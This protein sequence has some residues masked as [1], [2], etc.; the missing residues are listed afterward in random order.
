MIYPTVPSV[1]NGQR[2]G[3]GAGEM[4]QHSHPRALTVPEIHGIVADYA[5]AARN[6]LDAGFDGVEIH[7]ANGYLINQF[8]DSEANNRTD[9]YGGCL[10]NRLRFLR[11]VAGAVADAVGPEKVGVRLAPLTTLQGA[12]DS[13][14]E[15]TYLAAVAAL[16]DIGIAYVHIAE[17]D[18]D[19]APDMPRTFKEALRSTFRGV[20]IYAGNYDKERAERALEEGW[21]DMIGFGRA[22]IA[23][24]DLPYRFEQDL[25]L[26]EPDKDSFF[27]GDARGLTDYPFSR[28]A[29][30]GAL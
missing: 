27:G 26:N 23:N 2:A 6:A 7:A 13:N 18:W 22:F 29:E 1:K 15:E 30:K 5:R 17:A 24:P 16:D 28:Q 4:I 3:S 10:E 9:E 19:D 14:P 20:M 12:V 8:I 11:E 25:P 21:A